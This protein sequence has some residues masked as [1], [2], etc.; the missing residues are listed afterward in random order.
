M[1]GLPILI[2]SR[3]SSS[4][5]TSGVG[6]G[7]GVALPKRKSNTWPRVDSS[8]MD[9]RSETGIQKGGKRVVQEG[10]GVENVEMK[11]LPTSGQKI[12]AKTKDSKADVEKEAEGESAGGIGFWGWG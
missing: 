10:E 4:L 9:D 3:P 2:A 12:T 7:A 5:N 6:A 8:E 1:I 11:P